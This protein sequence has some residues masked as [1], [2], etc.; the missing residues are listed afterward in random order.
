MVIHSSSSFLDEGTD[1]LKKLMVIHSRSSFFDQTRPRTRSSSFLVQV[2]PQRVPGHPE[3]KSGQ[4][5]IRNGLLEAILEASRPAS[6]P[7]SQAQPLG[8]VFSTK[9]TRGQDRRVFSSR[10][11]P[12]GPRPPGGQKWP[13]PGPP[14]AP[15]GPLGPPG[16]PGG[17]QSMDCL[18]A[19]LLER[20]LLESRIA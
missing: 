19:A 9:R 2:A 7:A 15:K 5:L 3:A 20:A 12:N 17:P 11:A 6:K 13:N 1:S 14:G 18:R 4:N 16:A 10:L 8:R